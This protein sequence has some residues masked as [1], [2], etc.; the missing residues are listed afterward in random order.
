MHALHTV[1]A[2]PDLRIAAGRLGGTVSYD[3][4]TCD[5]GTMHAGQLGRLANKKG[6]AQGAQVARLG[7]FLRKSASKVMPPAATVIRASGA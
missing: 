1:H 7:N 2:L 4:P 3:L 5:G 6:H